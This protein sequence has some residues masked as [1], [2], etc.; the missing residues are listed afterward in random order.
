MELDLNR[1][2]DKAKECLLNGIKKYVEVNG[3]LE[4]ENKPH[5]VHN[6]RLVKGI[7]TEI[8]LIYDDTDDN[9]K[10]LSISII[11]DDDEEYLLGTVWDKDNGFMIYSYLDDENLDT[12]NL[13]IT[14]LTNKNETKTNS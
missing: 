14:C 3:D 7:S 9:N 4:F 1:Y 11:R 8:S 13:I 2:I 10:L 5:L 12:L 6:E